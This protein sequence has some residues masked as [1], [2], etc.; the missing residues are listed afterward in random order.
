MGKKNKDRNIV[1]SKTE[2][3]TSFID[4]LKF[5]Q[6]NKKPDGKK[7]DDKSKNIVSQTPIA[8]STSS[9]TQNSVQR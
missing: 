2:Q 3:K 1:V 9:T 4:K 5:M 8:F 7:E 6:K